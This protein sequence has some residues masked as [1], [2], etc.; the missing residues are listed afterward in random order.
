[1]HCVFYSLQENDLCYLI[2]K[3]WAG[4]S[5]V[6]GEKDLFELIL[7]RWNVT[8]HWSPWNCILLTTD[9]AR[10]H[11]KLDDPEKVASITCMHHN[12]IS[13]DNALLFKLMQS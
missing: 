7:V 6:S 13:F 8:E 5:A 4:Q 11:V 2:E 10:A 1:M 3:I 9:E 12:K